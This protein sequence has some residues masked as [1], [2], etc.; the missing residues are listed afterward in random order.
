MWGTHRPKCEPAHA[1]PSV[2]ALHVPWYVAVGGRGESAGDTTVLVTPGMSCALPRASQ[3][4]RHWST[5]REGAELQASKHPRVTAQGRKRTPR[6]G[7]AQE[8]D[9]PKVAD[10]TNGL[11]LIPRPVLSTGDQTTSITWSQNSEQYTGWM[12]SELLPG[13]K[14][15]FWP[16]AGFHLFLPDHALHKQEPQLVWHVAEPQPQPRDTLQEQSPFQDHSLPFFRQP[17]QRRMPLTFTAFP[18]K[19]KSPCLLS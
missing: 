18:T 9:I 3:E 8:G 16:P 15:E 14:C 2:L 17:R 4:G 7:E 6:P 10:D 12:V 19:G 11:V 13:L 1:C 5:Y